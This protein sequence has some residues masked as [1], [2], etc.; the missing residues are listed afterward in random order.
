[1]GST[2]KI[3]KVG[4]WVLLIALGLF[5][6]AQVFRPAQTNPVADPSLALE[7]HLPVE[8]NV[9]AILYRSC[10]DCH[11][12]KTRW[13]WYAN[14]APVSWFVIDHVNDGRSQMNFSEWGSY[15]KDEQ[16]NL[17][18]GICSL[19]KSGEMP[20]SSYTPMHRDSK[21]TGQDLSVLCEWVNR[22]QLRLL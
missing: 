19:S 22:S 6:A 13:P 3:W 9:A 16:H 18:R 5:A 17:L 15:P 7:S 1:M 12:N 8:P 21:L 11:S 20:L 4:R 10:A 14:V 2:N